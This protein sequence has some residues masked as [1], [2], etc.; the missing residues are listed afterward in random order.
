MSLFLKTYYPQ[1]FMVAV[2]NNFGG[3][4]SRE[5]YFLELFKCGGDITHPASIAAISI[6]TFKTKSV[7]RLYSYQEP[8]K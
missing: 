3:F 7:R 8:A 5:L 1:E 2:I 4:Y 6:Q